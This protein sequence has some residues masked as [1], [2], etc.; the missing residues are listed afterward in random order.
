MR[1]GRRHFS[2]HFI[3]RSKVVQH[4][5]QQNMSQSQLLKGV[6][7]ESDDDDDDNPFYEH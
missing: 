6:D 7:F 2:Y 4:I 1:R 3:D 5:I